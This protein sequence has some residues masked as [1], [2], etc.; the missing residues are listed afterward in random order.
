MAWLV[1][2]A[3]LHSA[4]AAVLPT[5]F[6][7]TR[8]A[9]ALDPTSMASAPDGRLFI[10]EKSGRIRILKNGALLPAPFA[11]LDAD[12]FDERGLL[13]LA[14]DP[15]FAD[16]HFIYVYYTAKNPSHN[17]IS[18]FTASGDSASGGEKV[19]LELNNLSDHGNHNG[20]AML[21]GK[22]GMLYVATGNN[23]DNANS[24]SMGNLLGK[25][26]R[27]HPDGSIPTDNPF[28]AS[29]TGNNRAIWALG[30]RN[31]FGMAVHPVTGKIMID[32]VGENTWEEID[33]GVAGANYGWPNAE[34]HAAI[35][36]TGLTG[37]YRDPV[38]SYRHSGSA[39]ITGGTFY[40][41]AANTFGKAFADAYFFSDYNEGW[42]KYL[43]PAKGFAISDFAT[44][45]NRPV[46]VEA[47]PDGS[48][49]YL[50]RGNHIP[51]ALPGSTADNGITAD[52][53]LFRIKGPGTPT[54]IG[55]SGTPVFQCVL[56]QPG[57]IQ[58]PPGKTGLAFC[59]LSG[60]VAWESQGA[61]RKAS[62]GIDIP[63][64]LPAGVYR[65][66]WH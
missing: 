57:H 26:L 33:E 42:I 30:L 55:T 15:A 66:I 58:L 27:L 29:A 3:R 62:A 38:S 7:E 52:G 54:V 14:F 35:A 25:I 8:L 21:F 1:L 20:G 23:R 60:R 19:I 63:S 12:N 41:P 31:P 40:H 61:A 34:G 64:A 6:S 4:G 47:G 18:R 17:R 46:D 9:Q 50:M 13:G 53:Q 44:G 51:G 5:G 16:N 2:A 56:S 65:V 32:E 36:P 28:Y 11:T 45:I 24:Q 49:Y 37:T 59:D 39:A 48:L 22:D 43:D 10:C